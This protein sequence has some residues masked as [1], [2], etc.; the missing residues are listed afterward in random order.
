M[1]SLM[2]RGKYKYI[3]QYIV[4][5]NEELVRLDHLWAQILAILSHKTLE[6][7]AKTNKKTGQ[8]QLFQ[9]TIK[10]I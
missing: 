5:H 4:L 10:K 2:S 8:L 6:L 3:L 1:M 7:Y 9:K